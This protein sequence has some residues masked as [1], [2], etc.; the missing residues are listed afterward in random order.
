MVDP[1]FVAYKIFIILAE[2]LKFL[3]Q[4]DLGLGYTEF[5]NNFFLDVVING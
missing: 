2:S 3:P 5:E 1:F 4:V